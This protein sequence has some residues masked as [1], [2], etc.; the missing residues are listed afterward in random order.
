MEL[1]KNI[2]GNRTKRKWKVR[3]KSKIGVFYDVIL[4]GYNY[5]KCTCFA[6]RSGK[7]CSHIKYIK[8]NHE[9]SV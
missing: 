7:I 1:I 5:Y 9:N 8:F 3:S 4:L 6:S 2:I